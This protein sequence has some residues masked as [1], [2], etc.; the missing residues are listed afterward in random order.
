[1]P[2]IVHSYPSSNAG[3]CSALLAIERDAA[4]LGCAKATITKLRLV[5]EELYTNT[6]RH[7]DAAVDALVIISLQRNADARAHLRYED[8]SAAYDPF[9]ALQAAPRR[10]ALRSPVEDRPVGRLGITLVQGLSVSATYARVEPRNR[11]DV[12]IDDAA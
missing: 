12:I 10:A 5:V 8:E 1:M 4:Q 9:S 6:L 11:I 7:S 3:L 2:L